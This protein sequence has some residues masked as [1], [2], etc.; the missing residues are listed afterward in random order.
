MPLYEYAC[1]A[2]RVVYQ[3]RHGV[4]EPRPERC[5]QCSGELRKV[6]LSWEPVMSGDVAGYAIERAAAASGAFEFVGAVAGRTST[7]Y[8]DDGKPRWPGGRAA[9]RDIGDNETLYYRVRAFDG[10][11]GGR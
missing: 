6:P 3:T 4:N 2:C 7:V 5:P 1:D 10:S 11:G 9:S 8:V